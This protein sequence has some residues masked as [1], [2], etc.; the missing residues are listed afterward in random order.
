[1]TSF[2]WNFVD[3]RFVVK[4]CSRWANFVEVIVSVILTV[5]K[6]SDPAR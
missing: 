1:M 6:N 4:N 5:M 2:V 3:P